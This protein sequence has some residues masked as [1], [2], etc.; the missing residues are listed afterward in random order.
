MMESVSII[1]LIKNYNKNL[2]M[3]I[4]YFRLSKIV[5]SQD[6]I[7]AFALLKKKIISQYYQN[8]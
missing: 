1:R 7:R 2:K 6:L 8:N 5:A 3:F 4:I